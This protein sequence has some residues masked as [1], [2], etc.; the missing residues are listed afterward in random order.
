MAVLYIHFNTEEKMKVN[1]NVS[2]KDYKGQPIL[3]NGNEVIIADYVAKD[4][5][6]LAQ[7]DGKPVDADKM[8]L[9]YKLST[10]IVGNPNEVELTS[11][12][13]TFIKEIM[14]KSLVVGCYGQ[15]VDILENN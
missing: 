15:L 9:A 5:F 3:E 10:R 4:L 6:T 8:L 11:E 12:E 7:L 13:I 14:S 2:F 1:L